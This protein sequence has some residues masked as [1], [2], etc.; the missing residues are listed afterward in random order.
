MIENNTEYQCLSCEQF[1]H[2]TYAKIYYGHQIIPVC[3]MRC[4]NAVMAITGLAN[5]LINR[6]DKKTAWIEI[7]GEHADK[8]PTRATIERSVGNV[9]TLLWSR[10]DV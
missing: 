5:D 3:E 4:M 7:I 1:R 2:V 9:G 10:D 8:S 6:T